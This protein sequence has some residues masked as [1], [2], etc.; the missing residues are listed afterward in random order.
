MIAA[1]FWWK[2]SNGLRRARRSGGC[3][4]FSHRRAYVPI[5]ESGSFRIAGR[6]APP[7]PAELADAASLSSGDHDAEL[8]RID[9]RLLNQ[10]LIGKTRTFT[11]E[12][13]GRIFTGRLD[14]AAGADRVRSIRDGSQLRLT[15]VLWMQTDQANR[16][17][18]TRFCCA[19]R[20][21]SRCSSRLPG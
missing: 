16:P 9:G 20:P 1:A 14:Q 6:G 15:G 21:I 3:R 11:M 7:A 13:G 4:R 18:P 10:S 2:A 12:L 19:R 5:L 17:F 8:V